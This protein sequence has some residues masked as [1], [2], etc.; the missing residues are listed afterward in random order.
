MTPVAQEA[1]VRKASARHQI[2]DGDAFRYRRLLWQQPELAGH[3]ARLQFGD[4]VAV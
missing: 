2:K 1:L 3:L 4:V